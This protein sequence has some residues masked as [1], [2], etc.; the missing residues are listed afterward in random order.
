MEIKALGAGFGRTGTNSL[1][2]ALEELGYGPSYH[3][4]EVAS[5]PEHIDLWNRAI[6]G[7]ALEVDK[8]FANYTSAVDW[9]AVAFLPEL[10]RQ[11]PDAKVVL[12][13]RDSN[14]W[15]ESATKT[16]FKFMPLS[17]LVSDNAVQKMVDMAKRLIL[18]HVFSNKHFDKD[19]CVGVYNRHIEGVTQL[20]PEDRLL[21]YKVSDGW[22]P[23]C[24]FL[25]VS[26]PNKPFPFT[27]DRKSFL[28]NMIGWAV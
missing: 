5:N 6:E 16:I 26:V 27:N 19:H 12:T 24:H 4:Y 8:L 13:L 9:P 20:V 1:K 23:L 7:H 17:H 18:E 28:K 15:F 3:M 21:M 14:D 10:L 11:Y 2:L 22:G 25:G